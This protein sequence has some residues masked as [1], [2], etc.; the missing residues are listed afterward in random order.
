MGDS[1][2]EQLRALGLAKD[3]GKADRRAGQ[4]R[5]TKRG[6]RR[7]GRPSADG[8]RGEPSLDEAYA[9]RAREERRAAERSRQAK[10]AAERRRREIN[11]KIRRI[12]EDCRLNREDASV[13][14]HFLYKGRIRKIFVTMEQQRALADGQMGIVYLTG[15][16]HLLAIDP[17]DQVRSISGDHVV[18]LK[19]DDP[20]EDER[21]VPDDLIW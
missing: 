21:P 1:L 13:P 20:D 10:L 2:R 4:G 16:Y 8:F 14:R 9:L 15:G 6:K 7:D 3:Q 18:E 17:L 5:R 19:D 11:E 12:V